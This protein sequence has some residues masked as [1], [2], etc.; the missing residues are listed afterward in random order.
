MNVRCLANLSD[1]IAFFYSNQIKENAISI[2]RKC[3]LKEKDPSIFP[4][5]IQLGF[6]H[7]TLQRYYNPYELFI[8]S[9]TI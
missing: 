9:I 1:K 2:R 5:H 6:N 7:R 8:L 3:G 4:S